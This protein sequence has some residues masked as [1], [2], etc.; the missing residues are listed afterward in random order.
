MESE[1]MTIL[2]TQRLSLSQLHVADALFIY[3]LLNS[4][5]WLQFIGDRGIKTLDDA[6]NYIEKG[7]QASYAKHG[8]GL[9]LVKLK[10]DDTS[11]GICGLIKREALMHPDI[12][13][14]FLT[15][16]IGK[17][18]AFESASAVLNHGRTVL[19]LD[20]ILAI[21]NPDNQRSIGLLEK[22]GLVFEKHIQLGEE[23][24][25]LLLFSSR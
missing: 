24:K 15:E 19:G 4:P 9:Y 2:E 17:G 1:T 7:P 5:G 16:F 21:T 11:I 25:E 8:F 12:G 10:T 14:A 13:F 22:L 20:P 18:Y 23:E 3:E 6:R